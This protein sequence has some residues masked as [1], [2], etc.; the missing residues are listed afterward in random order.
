M[1]KVTVFF[2]IALVLLGAT[3]FVLTGEKFPTSLIPVGFGVL[4]VIFGAL[5]AMP[6]AGHLR[7]FM[8]IA[9]AIGLLGF[10]GTGM[11]L[12]DAFRL[13]QGKVFP[14]PAAVEEKAAMAILML[15]FVIL[16]VRSFISARRARA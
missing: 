4:F 16:C 7:L 2:G 14:Y 1:A 15:I 9:V 10:L 11:S 12:L 13:F 6:G 5:A 3:S 8:H